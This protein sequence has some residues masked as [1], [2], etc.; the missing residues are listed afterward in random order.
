MQP[1]SC[2]GQ[3][4]R[5][6]HE[7]KTLVIHETWSR[8]ADTPMA[9]TAKRRLCY[10]GG[11]AV[12]VA[13]RAVGW[14]PTPSWHS[15]SNPVPGEVSGYPWRVAW[16]PEFWK[17][18]GGAAAT[19]QA[20]GRGPHTCAGMV[21]SQGELT[22]PGARAGTGSRSRPLPPAGS[23]RRRRPARTIRR[24]SRTSHRICECPRRRPAR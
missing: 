16:R 10:G 14:R 9:G 24:E 6:T 23:R 22:A 1:M 11:G 18:V 5:E 8:F 13:Y 19:G 4:D 21:L 20:A 15:C 7:G 2:K 12:A 3:S 17:F